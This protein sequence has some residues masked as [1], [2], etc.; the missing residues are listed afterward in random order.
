[1]KVHQLSKMIT[2][3]YF[4][5]YLYPVSS[6]IPLDETKALCTS[7]EQVHLL[8]GFCFKKLIFIKYVV[9]NIT[10]GTFFF[11]VP[12]LKIEFLIQYLEV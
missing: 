9:F 2:K 10:L 5:L 6:V 8:E 4:F 3:C 1:M 12:V 11:K 7:M